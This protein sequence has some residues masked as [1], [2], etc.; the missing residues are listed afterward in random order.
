MSVH[1]ELGKA[2]VLNQSCWSGDVLRAMGAQS[3]SEGEL[4]LLQQQTAY[5][6]S[7]NHEPEQGSTT[8]I[9][10]QCSGLAIWEKENRDDFAL[11]LVRN[12]D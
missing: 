11:F 8:T 3:L 1:E 6:V 2:P 5:R 10:M 12:A 9:P 4:N 7:S